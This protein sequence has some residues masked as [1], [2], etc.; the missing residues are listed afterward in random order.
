MSTPRARSTR[1]SP[2]RRR[3]WRARPASA[4]EGI[5]LVG[6]GD[7]A[8]LVMAIQREWKDDPKGQVKLLAYKPKAKEWSAVRYP[9]EAAERRL[10]RP[11]GDHR[12]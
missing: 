7:D 8:T 6:A 2:S 12:T 11:V 3:C 5:T 9:L 10:G 4:L 1:K